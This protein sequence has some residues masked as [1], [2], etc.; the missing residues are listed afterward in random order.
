M[1]DFE[2]VKKIL[3]ENDFMKISMVASFVILLY[4]AYYFYKKYNFET[5]SDLME[6]VT[7]LMDDERNGTEQDNNNVETTNID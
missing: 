2:E 5:G 7:S 4:L 1:V 3:M 6:G